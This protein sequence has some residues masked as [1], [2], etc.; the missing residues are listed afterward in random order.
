VTVSRLSAAANAQLSP[1]PSTDPGRSSAAERG[2][3]FPEYVGYKQEPKADGPTQVEPS[4][5][6]INVFADGFIHG[7]AMP[8]LL[9]D[10]VVN[11]RAL[12]TP[13]LSVFALTRAVSFGKFQSASFAPL[14]HGGLTRAGKRSIIGGRRV[15]ACGDE[16]QAT[17]DNPFHGRYLSGRI[18]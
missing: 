5:T 17:E 2:L 12:D 14:V 4:E 11:R 6:G 9:T 15:G 7:S 1:A 13:G 18:Q 3:V 8:R 10:A 16:S